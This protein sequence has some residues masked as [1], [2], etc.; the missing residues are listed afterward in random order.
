MINQTLKQLY[1]VHS[2]KV[3]DKWS[4]YLIEYDRLFNVY[5]DKPV[6]LL[7][8]GIQNGGSLEIWSKYFFN[9]KKL[10]GCDINPDCSR[11]VYEDSRIMVVLGD[12]NSDLVE[13]NVLQHMPFFDIVIDDGSHRSSDI[14]KSFARYFHNLADGGIFVVEDLHCSYWGEFEGGLF[15]PY[16]S[17]TFFKRLADIIN[18]EHWGIAKSR[19]E[20]LRGFFLKYDILIDEDLLTH[21]HSIQFFNS[22]CVV[23]K[24]SPQNN[25][26]GSRFVSGL[27]ESIEMGGL[28]LQSSSTP[29]PSQINN[30]WTARLIPP[31][32]DVLRLESEIQCLNNKIL[33]R[34]LEINNINKDLDNRG[35]EIFTLKKV[36]ED[37]ERKVDE[38][39]NSTSWRITKPLRFIYTHCANILHKLSIKS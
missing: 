19:S 22:I 31:D 27:D 7:E 29:E 39:N 38:L 11:L 23:R 16:S 18:H 25:S 34:N 2:G 3:S 10:I 6:N 14:V 20:I 30:Q 9:A 35:N 8:I 37:M 4:S 32:E 13:S 33:E 15:Y 36:V 1:A 17:I 28:S 24:E 12:A 5:R 21:I 26:L